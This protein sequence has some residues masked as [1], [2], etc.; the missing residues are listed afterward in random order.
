[1]LCQKCNKN[2][3]T[4]FVSAIVDGKNSQMY[5]CTECAKEFHNSMNSDMQIPFP[6]EDVLSNMGINQDIL[7]AWKSLIGNPEIDENK[8]GF[9]IE[10]PKTEIPNKVEENKEELDIK[11][12]LC[13]TTFSEYKKTGKLGCSKCYSNFE[14]QLKPIIEGI[15][16]YSNHIGK[17][18]KDAYQDVEA[19]REVEQLK[20]QLNI[21]IEKEE[22]EQAAELRDRIL[23]LESNSI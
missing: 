3:A 7:K 20:E 6:I 23:E 21:A 22:Y 4:V 13:N 5:L 1:M 12:S 18:P 16:G 9:E 15:Y 10:E 11:C 2:I 19:I 14:E 8:N 17:F